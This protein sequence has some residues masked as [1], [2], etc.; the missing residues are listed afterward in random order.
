MKISESE[1]SSRNNNFS[2]QSHKAVRAALDKLIA[3][4]GTN[5]SAISNMLGRRPIST[6]SFIAAARSV[7]QRMTAGFWLNSLPLMRLYWAR[8]KA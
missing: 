7:W 6:S 3:D 4:R 5:Y 1:Q 2:D 8:I